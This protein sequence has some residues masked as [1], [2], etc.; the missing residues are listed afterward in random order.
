[1]TQRAEVLFG[2]LTRLAQTTVLFASAALVVWRLPPPDQG[3]YWA[4]TGLGGLVQVGE[5]ALTQVVLQTSAHHVARGDRVQLARFWRTARLLACCLVPIAALA[6]LAC[7]FALL[8]SHEAAREPAWRIPWVAFVIALAGC[9]LLGPWIGFIEGAVSIAASWRF[10]GRLEAVSGVA[11]LAALALGAGLWSL[12]AYAALRFVLIAS[13]VVLRR[14]D[15]RRPAADGYRVAEWLRE[16][17]PY[18]WKLAVTAVT[19]FFIYRAFTPIVFAGLGPDAAARFGLSVA[20]MA[21]WLSI[22][23]AWP[24][25]QIGRIGSLASQ[26][27]RDELRVTFRTMLYASTAFTAMGA[28]LILAA[29]RAADLVGIPYSA[30]SAGLGATA[31]LLAAGVLHH[32]VLCASV[33]LRSERRDPLLPYSIAGSLITVVALWYATRMGNL[34]YVAFAYLA[35]AC[36]GLLMGWHAFARHV[37]SWRRYLHWSSA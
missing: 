1:M 31:M 11:L 36:L 23:V 21:S 22:T 25:S 15:F 28:L 17:W 9:Q 29:L 13:W 8:G 4:M 30:K 26:E 32:V 5:L 10:Q 2:L 34:S 27:K 12:V 37:P 19:S 16:V 18:Q 14:A 7:G 24:S 35:C 6:V 3:Y 33:L 20:I